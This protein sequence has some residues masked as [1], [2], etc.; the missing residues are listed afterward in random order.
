[1]IEVTKTYT[2]QTVSINDLMSPTMLESQ[3]SH[4]Y[5]DVPKAQR[6]LLPCLKPIRGHS[7]LGESEQ[8]K[9]A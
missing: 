3:G 2:E 4:V 8:L 9:S 5:K 1:M 6:L 7:C